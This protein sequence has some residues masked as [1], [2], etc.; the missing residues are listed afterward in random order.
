M[1]PRSEYGNEQDQIMQSES[2]MFV[3]V[4]KRDLW[5]SFE[6]DGLSDPRHGSYIM[7]TCFFTFVFWPIGVSRTY[8]IQRRR[9]DLTL[10]EKGARYAAKVFADIVE[11]LFTDPKGIDQLKKEFE[12]HKTKEYK[13]MY[14][15]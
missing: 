3:G 4:R 9:T 7:S 1:H 6:P 14:S 10:G 11:D 5:K 13:P 12:E 2:P 15:E 8:G